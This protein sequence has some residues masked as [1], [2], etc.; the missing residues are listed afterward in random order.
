MDNEPGAL[1]ISCP[2]T[3]ATTAVHSVGWA[4]TSNSLTNGALTARWSDTGGFAFYRQGDEMP[5]LETAPGEGMVSVYIITDSNL[6][7]KYRCPL[8]FSCADVHCKL[9]PSIFA[10][11]RNSNLIS[12]HLDLCFLVGPSFAATSVAVAW[13]ICT[14]SDLIFGESL[15][16]RGRVSH[17]CL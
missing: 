7:S 15:E 17:S 9:L 1:D 8:L 12:T 2:P 13:T 14:Y 11:V 4:P 6:L 10:D 16:P 3:N 5:V